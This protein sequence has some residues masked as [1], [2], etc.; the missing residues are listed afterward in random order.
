MVFKSFFS[1]KPQIWPSVP[2]PNN[3]QSRFFR[4]ENIVLKHT[5]NLIL[6]NF[7]NY[8]LEIKL[9]FGYFFEFYISCY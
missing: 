8:N 5:H 9:H 4:F 7:Q 6:K 2:K 1:N 3:A